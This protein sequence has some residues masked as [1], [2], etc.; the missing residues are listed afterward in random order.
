MNRSKEIDK[1]DSDK[2]EKN[3]L[4]EEIDY[5]RKQLHNRESDEQLIGI[6]QNLATIA[7]S[8]LPSPKPGQK[9]NP[10][11]IKH[12][13]LYGD[14]LQ[15]DPSKGLKQP[16]ITP[17]GLFPS[18]SRSNNMLLDES[19]AHQYPSND[20]MSI[21]D[22]S[23]SSNNYRTAT[24]LSHRASS[25]SLIQASKLT[26]NNNSPDKQRFQILDQKQKYV[27]SKFKSNKSNKNHYNNSNQTEGGTD[28]SNQVIFKS[29]SKRN[30]N[31]VLDKFNDQLMVQNGFKTQRVI[32]LS[33]N[34]GMSLA[35]KR[36]YVEKERNL[37]N[38]ISLSRK[39]KPFFERHVSVEQLL[40]KD[41]F[42]IVR[43]RTRLILADRKRFLDQIMQKNDIQPYS[44]Q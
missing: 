33:T 2:F 21:A 10:K 4:K 22:Q 38:L 32:N 44:S 40:L 5:L 27:S 3:Q 42:K 17:F 20:Y 1:I 30:L 7:K 9:M 34:F 12:K 15:F 14:A 31:D 23:I 43:E 19:N 39:D 8:V 37:E 29:F 28:H 36:E 6:A 18:I 25:Q 35:K 24:I 26:S 13:K 16:Q 11:R 41:E